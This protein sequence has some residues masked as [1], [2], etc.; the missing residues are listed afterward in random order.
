M[1]QAY[2]ADLLLYAYLA[3]QEELEEGAETV[4]FL[5]QPVIKT[6]LLDALF[7]EASKRGI[8]RTQI[9]VALSDAYDDADDG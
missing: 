2:E 4:L 9:M 7:C 6:S 8:L 3:A 5:G 1:Q